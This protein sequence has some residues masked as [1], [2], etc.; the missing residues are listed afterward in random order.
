M[1]KTSCA[2][3]TV[4]LLVSGG[5]YATLPPVELVDPD[6]GYV[7]NSTFGDPPG[8][9]SMFYEMAALLAS[10]GVE[11]MEGDWRDAD[12]ESVAG[13]MDGDGI[14]DH[15]QLAL[16]G[17]VL[18][19][20]DGGKEGEGP[21]DI[22]LQFEANKALYASLVGEI[23][24]LLDAFGPI[25]AD[26]ASVGQDLID[27]GTLLGPPGDPLVDL[28]TQMVGAG[29][30]FQ[31]FI[32]EFGIL[33][34]ALPLYENWFAGMAGLSSEMSATVDGLLN[35]LLE[36]LDGVD[37]Q[38]AALRDGILMA[39]PMVR[40]FD[41]AL[42]DQMLALAAALDAAIP[43]LDIVAPDFEVYGVFGGKTVDEPFSAFGDYNEDLTD[44]QGHYDA[45]GG[46][47]PNTDVARPAFV[48]AASS[49][50]HLMPVAGGLALA[51]LAGLAVVGGARSIRK[52]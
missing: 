15:Y 17:A 23:V 12:L 27:L 29:A 35:D 5:A 28:G 24:T 39:E 50:Q 11:E 41:A 13:P 25:A 1:K 20:A 6:C 45:V 40:P 19:A 18:C 16:L 44:N 3:V 47:G 51:L 38:L 14:V 42:A 36:E 32:D 43:L 52:K 8:F 31:G 30:V 26:L 37:A 21:A 7:F 4:A 46:G 2:L 48:A 49:N 34:V 33:A 10:I 22:L 9:D